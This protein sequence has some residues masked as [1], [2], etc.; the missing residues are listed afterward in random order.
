M[1]RNRRTNTLATVA[2]A[3]V[4]ICLVLGAPASSAGGAASRPRVCAPAISFGVLPTWAR[5]GFSSPKPRLP[6]AVGRRGQIAA[7]VFGYPLAAPPAGRRNNKILWVSR[8]D[9]AGVGPAALWIRAQRMAGS[10]AVGPAATRIVQGGPGP[11]I[12]NLPAAGCWR[13]ELAWSGRTDT[14]DL[15][16]R[17]P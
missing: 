9:P 3:L 8:R 10:H 15:R 11:S 6:H 2:P 17:T 1:T 4:G 13:L 5:T 14:L 12:V 16:Y 7:L